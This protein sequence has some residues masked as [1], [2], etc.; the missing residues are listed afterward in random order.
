[1]FFEEDLG[2]LRRERFRPH[3]VLTY[4]RAAG[5]RIRQDLDANPGGVRSVWIAALSFFAVAF[6]IAM[7]LAVAYDRSL[8]YSFF[9]NTALW[10]LP[11]FTLVTINIGMLRDRDDYRLSALNVPIVLSLLRVVLIPGIALTLIRGHL[12]LALIAY[13]IA[14]LSD[15]ADGWVARRWKQETK[16][17]TV[18]DPF[19][20]IVFGLALFIALAAAHILPVWV[21]AAAALRFGILLVGGAYLLLWVGPLRIRPTWFGKL[22]GVVTATLAGLLILLHAT[23]GGTSDALI[24]L[25][26]TALGVLMWGTVVYAFVLGL[27]NLR[28]MTGRGADAPGRVVGDVRWGAQ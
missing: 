26:E 17:G 6:L 9:R 16:L 28:R 27:V 18:L 21:M 5:I 24:P 15:V 25:T 2:T 1:M 11:T 3:A 10:I 12:T 7:V 14:A 20:D 4:L 19:V 22:T 13:L 8:A 23:R